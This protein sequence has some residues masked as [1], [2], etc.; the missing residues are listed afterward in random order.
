MKYIAI[1]MILFSLLTS[2]TDSPSINIINSLTSFDIDPPILKEISSTSVYD[3]TLTFSESIK[4]KRIKIND[5]EVNKY[6]I[7]NNKL[8]IKTSK[9]VPILKG[10]TS[11]ITVS[12]YAGNLSHYKLQLYGKNTSIPKVKI[13]EL[14]T[15][16]TDTQPE[17]IELEVQTNGNIEGLYLSVGSKDNSNTGFILPNID[18][19]RGDFIVIY[20]NT[21][22]KSELNTPNCYY[23]YAKQDSALPSNNGVIV[24]Y[25]SK[26]GNGEILDALVYSDFN[27]TTHGGFGN[28]STLDSVNQI[29]DEF[30]WFGDPVDST[31]MTSTRTICRYSNR[32]DTNTSDD[33]YICDTRNSSFGLPNNNKE[34]EP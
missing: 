26:M 4:V 19:N 33:F 27:S 29:K 21:I 30:E 18:V 12:D 25:D 10:N 22:P 32:A 34:Y 8:F 6:S 2:C 1:L 20:W 28:K 23:L 11:E 17:R 7:I 31:Y 14:L 16:G 3:F 24:L 9:S 5:N 15:R 13:N